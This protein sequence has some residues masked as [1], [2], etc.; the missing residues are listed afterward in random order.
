MTYCPYKV[1]LKTDSPRID[2]GFPSNM[3]SWDPIHLKGFLLEYA[4]NVQKCPKLS[5]V[6]PTS[7][8]NVVS[9]NIT[10][11]YFDGKCV[12]CWDLYTK[13]HFLPIL[14]SS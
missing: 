8:C 2:K 14:L 12:N 4:L 3:A 1:Q 11:H 10:K 9:G 13:L 6:N 7:V 5:V